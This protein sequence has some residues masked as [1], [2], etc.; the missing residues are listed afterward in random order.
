VTAGL[1]LRLLPQPFEPMPGNPGVMG[2]V[3]GIA[4]AKII[5]HRPEINAL[6][7]QVVAAGVAEHVG[8]WLMLFGVLCR[9]PARPVKIP[10]GSELTVQPPDKGTSFELRLPPE[11]PPIIPRRPRPSHRRLTGSSCANQWVLEQSANLYDR[12]WAE[13]NHHGYF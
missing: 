12:G 2:G 1:G 10:S 5:L 7:G 4:V 6:V 11:H 9:R 3:L 8:P 13:R